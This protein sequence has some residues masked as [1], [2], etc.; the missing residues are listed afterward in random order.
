MNNGKKDNLIT[1][2]LALSVVIKL[3]HSLQKISR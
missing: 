1:E 3:Q 2:I